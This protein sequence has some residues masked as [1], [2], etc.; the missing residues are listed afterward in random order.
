VAKEYYEVLDHCSSILNKYDGEHWALE[1]AGTA[2]SSVTT[3]CW[4]LGFVFFFF[5]SIGV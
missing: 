5:G 3:G 2:C 4:G 1:Q